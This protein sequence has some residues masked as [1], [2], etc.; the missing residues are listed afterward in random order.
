MFL[1]GLRLVDLLRSPSIH[2]PLQLLFLPVAGGKHGKMET[3][4]LEMFN[5][6]SRTAGGRCSYGL[7]ILKH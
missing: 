5:L 3:S 7:C 2:L 1:F 6:V 4:G